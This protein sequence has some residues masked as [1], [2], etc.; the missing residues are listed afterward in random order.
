MVWQRDSSVYGAEWGSAILP[1]VVHAS[2]VGRAY[3]GRQGRSLLGVSVCCG[4]GVVEGLCGPVDRLG[5]C[6]LGHTDSRR[7]RVTFGEGFE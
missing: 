1:S 5:L 3:V 6:G 7:S 2:P 4:S